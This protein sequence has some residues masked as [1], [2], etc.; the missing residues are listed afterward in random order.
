M[1]TNVNI[2][3]AIFTLN[4]AKLELN[5]AGYSFTKTNKKDQT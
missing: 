2:F 3:Y 5:K 1:L 4:S